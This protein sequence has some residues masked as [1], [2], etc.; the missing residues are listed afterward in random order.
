MHI[1][2]GLKQTSLFCSR[3]TQCEACAEI[4]VGVERVAR[5]VSE[6]LKVSVPEAF[7]LL[8]QSDRK[9]VEIALARFE[10]IFD[11]LEVKISKA[12]P[13]QTDAIS[14]S[15]DRSIGA[16][17]AVRRLAESIFAHKEGT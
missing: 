10:E 9:A 17:P 13:H 3:G 7:R 8:K 12:G 5:D 16:L 11:L 4:S 14:I 6:I 1:R 15:V 2:V